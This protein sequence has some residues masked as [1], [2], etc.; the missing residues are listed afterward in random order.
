MRRLL[1][2]SCLLSTIA[3]TACG[4][5]DSS[6][7]LPSVSPPPTP[8]LV[9]PA[10]TPT[11]AFSASDTAAANVPIAFDASGSTSP[12]GTALTYAWD[13]GDGQRGGG[14]TIAHV[15]ATGG[16]RNVTLTVVDGAG[17]RASQSK[18]ITVSV[19]APPSA[20]I[21]AQVA[22]K[23]VDGVAIDGVTVIPIGGG[24]G[25]ALTD[26]MG[27]ASLTLG[28]GAP[29]SLKLSKSGYADQFATLQLPSSAGTDAYVEATMRTRDVA[30]TLA[31]AAAGGTVSGRD[32]ATLTLPANALV[33]DAGTAVNGPVQIS[34]TPVDVTLAAAGGFPGQF[35][36]IRPDGA[37][38][39][40]VSFGTT[41]FVLTAGGSPVQIA[42]GAQATIE[43]PI[44]AERQLDGTPLAVGAS[45]PLWSLDETTGLWIQE[46]SGT[47]IASAFA[48]SGLALRASVSHLSWWN[49]DIGFD[50]YGPQ[51]K[52]V[53]DTDIGMPGAADTFA[54]AT[55]C[56]M[57]AEIDR[58]LGT[59]PAPARFVRALADPLAPR[60]AAFARRDVL[61]ITGG[62]TIPV[63]ANVNI[64]LSASALNGTWSG[65]TIV[66][67]PVGVQAEVLIKM[68]PLQSTG[69]APEAITL[70]FDSTRSLQLNQTA[71]YS[72]SGVV[73]KYARITAS[74]GAASN[75]DGTVRL[76]RGA[77]VLGSANFGVSQ[78]QM[79]VALP[80]NDTY[81]IEVV[82]TANAPGA[83]R[84]QAELLGGEVTEA[85]AFPFDI[86]KSLP[87]FTVY[88]GG[89]AVAQTGALYLA[90]RRMNTGAAQQLRMTGPSGNTVLDLPTATAGD[91][92]ATVAV[93]AAGNYAFSVQ[94][95]N[96]AAGDFHSMAEP[97]SWLPVAPTLPIESAFGIIDLIADRNGAP[98]L[99]YIRDVVGV[100]AY[101]VQ[102][103]RFNGTSWD[104]A[105][106]ELI[107]DRPCTGYGT[108]IGFTVDA[109]NNPI[110]VYNQVL[111]SGNGAHV[112]ARRYSGG[113][114]A[115]IGPNGGELPN[116]SAFS[117]TCPKP[118]VR[119]DA[120]GAPLVAYGAYIG[121]N[122]VY[123]QRFDGANWVD[124]AAGPV[125]STIYPSFDLNVDASGRPVLIVSDSSALVTRAYRFAATAW[126]ALG[127]NSGTLPL[128]AEL[129]EVYAPRIRF[130]A[131]GNP[132]VGFT[133]SVT[134]TPGIFTSGVAV[135]RFDGTTWSTT[136]GFRAALTDYV[137][138]VDSM[139]FEVVNGDAVLSISNTT[140]GGASNYPIVQ[141]NTAA[142]WTPIGLN[143]GEVPQFTQHGLTTSYGL[144]TRLL[145]VGGTL[146]LTLVENPGNGGG[147]RIVLLKKVGN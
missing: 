94:P 34:V 49:A 117:G 95:Q 29:V 141:K 21:N 56:N 37:S 30:Q 89:F 36:G 39:P 45:V 14:Q 50:P 90:H 48:P 46:G 86:T 147:Q 54:T 62:R 17:R 98:L 82:G 129:R 41:E 142:G 13:F 127:Q 74:R 19:A 80:A 124:L 20:M 72:F 93:P 91:T 18:S 27:K 59:S 15:F 143:K 24:A 146:Y 9:P 106:S 44:Y 12:N 51:P 71:R 121:S 81:I 16:L 42:A 73:P 99:A 104:V 11:A 130:D 5:S 103:R 75:M 105:A 88:R 58:G 114:W 97:T 67:G 28:M 23:T 118:V 119:I 78:G 126:Q 116:V 69:P 76:L 10:N 53:Y 3:F 122:G 55:I 138:N 140:S 83:Y 111:P 87:A 131:G 64:A 61:P 102:L 63:P 40:I 60:I 133:A 4:G 125:Q 1:L 65:R 110:V 132:V 70:P 85:L 26:A 135:Y 31:D 115:P 57:L 66:N 43:L 7:P 96:G 108:S 100:N 77:T 92:F 68:R 35:E 2:I 134:I 52:C 123:V 144:T 120:G 139:G 145:F 47:I 6:A 8:P 101:S 38:T 84:L 79:I 33:N 128:T 113:A 25:S 32:G 137:S 109:S 107:I 136:G 112:M 22:V